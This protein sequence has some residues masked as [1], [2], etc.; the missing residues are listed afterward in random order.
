MRYDNDTKQKDDYLYWQETK[1]GWNAQVQ[2]S[3][4][5][6]SFRPSSEERSQHVS[7]APLSKNESHTQEQKK[8]LKLENSMK[9]CWNINRGKEWKTDINCI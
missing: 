7:R 6:Y 5:L 8:K 1:W 2:Q 4:Y 3:F 9:N